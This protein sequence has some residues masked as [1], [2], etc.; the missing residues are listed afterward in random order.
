MDA[1]DVAHLLEHLDLDGDDSEEFG[2]RERLD[3]G[4]EGP[5]GVAVNDRTGLCEPRGGVEGRFL[6]GRFACARRGGVEVEEAPPAGPGVH[7]EQAAQR[8]GRR[9]TH[10]ILALRA[11]EARDARN[12][13]IDRVDSA[14]AQGRRA[15][16]GSRP[17]VV[18]ILNHRWGV[19][20][21]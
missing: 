3:A 7:R 21:P 19:C 11:Q 14:L 8:A 16:V 9:T 20:R 12:R 13:D 1:V 17:G 10:D 6:F 4:A 5:Q 15:S 2:D 18:I